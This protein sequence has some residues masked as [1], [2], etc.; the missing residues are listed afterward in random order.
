MIIVEISRTVLIKDVET[1]SNKNETLK[2][3]EE[4]LK[5]GKERKR[6]ELV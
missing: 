6:E 5:R 2:S 3:K 4:I 1:E